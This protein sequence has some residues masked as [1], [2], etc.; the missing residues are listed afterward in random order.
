MSE[1]KRDLKGLY[2]NVGLVNAKACVQFAVV[3]AVNKRGESTRS[4]A[5]HLHLTQELKNTALR[6]TNAGVGG[7]AHSTFG[8]AVVL[9]EAAKK[10][11]D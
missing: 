5:Q 3:G 1:L 10:E 7:V 4:K 2:A 8:V 11:K 9:E 6:S